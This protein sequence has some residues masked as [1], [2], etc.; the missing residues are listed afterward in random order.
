MGRPTS[1]TPRAITAWAAAESG[2][3]AIREQG[4]LPEGF[5]ISTK[6]DRDFETSV[7]DARHA[8]AVRSSKA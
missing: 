7:F 6:L 4:G 1:S 3:A 8:R 5:V 2:S